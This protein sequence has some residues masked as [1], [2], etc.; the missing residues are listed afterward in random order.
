MNEAASNKGR[1]R[2]ERLAKRLQK[3]AKRKEVMIGIDPDSEFGYNTVRQN[4]ILS[5]LR[6]EIASMKRMMERMT[7][8]IGNQTSGKKDFTA[9]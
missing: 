1:D 8:N 3:T 4:L 7:R 2:V 9:D 6:S 5:D